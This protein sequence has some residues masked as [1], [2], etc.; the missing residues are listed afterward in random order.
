VHGPTLADGEPDAMGVGT[1]TTKVDQHK[2]KVE[3]KQT[4]MYITQ[5][6]NIYLK[7]TIFCGY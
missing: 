4:Y 5:K 6:M 2:E 1:Y 7:V 3:D